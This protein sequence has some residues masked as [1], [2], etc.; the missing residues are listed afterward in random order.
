MWNCIDGMEGSLTGLEFPPR[1]GKTGLSPSGWT[2][3]LRE[4]E[5]Q[6]VIHRSQTAGLSNWVQFQVFLVTDH[7]CHFTGLSFLIFFFP[8]LTHSWAFVLYSL[9]SFLFSKLLFPVYLHRKSRTQTLFNIALNFLFLSTVSPV[10][11]L[12]PQFPCSSFLP[13]T[14]SWLHAQPLRISSVSSEP[15]SHHLSHFGS[16]FQFSLIPISNS[17]IRLLN[18]VSSA[19]LV[20]HPICS[21]VT[22]SSSQQCLKVTYVL[23]LILCCAF[24]SSQH[25]FPHPSLCFVLILPV[26]QF[27]ILLLFFLTDFRL[28]SPGPTSF[29]FY[30]L[31]DK[32]HQLQ[33]FSSSASWSSVATYPRSWSFLA[34]TQVRWFLA[35]CWSGSVWA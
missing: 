21:F 22:T 14:W 9:Q 25:E 33:C 11:A 3:F 35:L 10:S 17:L 13:C 12:C 20:S 5:T 2:S 4:H 8:P 23:A 28:W 26:S 18:H 29:S 15:A 31:F 32:T 19:R 16:L 24:S 30:F 7:V 34:W 1:E 27:F 6:S